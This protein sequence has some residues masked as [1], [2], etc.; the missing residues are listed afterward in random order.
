MTHHEHEL[1][2][3]T[4]VHA[5]FGYTLILAGLTRSSRCASLCHRILLRMA[6][7][8]IDRIIRLRT[9]LGSTLQLHP[10]DARSDTCYHSV[11]PTR[12]SLILAHLA[13]ELT[14]PAFG[15]GRLVVDVQDSRRTARYWDRLHNFHAHRIQVCVCAVH[16]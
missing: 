7:K 1:M 5:I 10:R 15:D 8:M 11:D 13:Y 16:D 9:V 3:S 12:L 4:T 6:S 2:L 14:I